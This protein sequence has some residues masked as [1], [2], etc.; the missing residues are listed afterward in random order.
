M[1]TRVTEVYLFALLGS[2]QAGKIVK[3]SAWCAACT[4]FR[5]G[6][7]SAFFGALHARMGWIAVGI[8]FTGC[9]MRQMV[10]WGGNG[11]VVAA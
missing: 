8:C 1:L 10:R 7:H 3:Q 11:P 9:K 2:G 6:L 4:G 5:A